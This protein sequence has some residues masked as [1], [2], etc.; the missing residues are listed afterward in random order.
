[1]L[2]ILNVSVAQNLRVGYE[3]CIYDINGELG[4]GRRF[5]FEYPF[6]NGK[7]EHESG[8]LPCKPNL[9]RK[10]LRD[11]EQFITYMD[12]DAF[13]IRKFD[14]VN[15]DDY[16]VG[17]TM[18]PQE[19]RGATKWPLIYGYLNSGI[20]FFNYTAA[21]FS[22]LD[23]WEKAVNGNHSKSDQEGLNTLVLQAT[24]LTKYNKTFKLRN[25]RIKVFHCDIYN[26]FYWPK[27][28]L[29]TTK[30]VHCKTDKR[31]ALEDWGHRAWI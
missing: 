9:I 15:S 20:L 18:R 29:L 16:D 12:A 21:A 17:V 22:F 27:K 31:D 10:G 30:I 4:F 2:S 14:E 8:R 3:V 23:M 24:D 1:M 26:F 6:L 5:D 7:N 11:H 25:I 19:M 28:P 13:A